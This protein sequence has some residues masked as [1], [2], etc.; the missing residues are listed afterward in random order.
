MPA[1]ETTPKCFICRK[2]WQPIYSATEIAFS[3]S[4]CSCLNADFLLNIRG[5]FKFKAPHRSGLSFLGA[6]S[7]CG[8]M[9]SPSTYLPREQ[10]NGEPRE[11]DSR[12]HATDPQLW[13][14]FSEDI[15]ISHKPQLFQSKMQP[16]LHS[17][18]PQK[19]RQQWK[20]NL[21]AQG[22]VR[23]RQICVHISKAL[24]YHGDT[25]SIRP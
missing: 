10:W 5:T 12:A 17:I 22:K 16:L 11:W 20:P 14:L 8:I 18:T 15:R 23:E 2:M 9:T 7:P 4:Q 19:S 25:Y 21:T 6:P 13:N 24:R 3:S 1:N